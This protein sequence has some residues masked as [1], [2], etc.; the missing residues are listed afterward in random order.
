MSAECAVHAGALGVGTC[1]RCGAFACSA[2]FDVTTGWCSACRSRREVRLRVPG[3]ARAA[4]WLSVL[5]ACGVLPLLAVGGLLGWLELR[6]GGEQARP[7][8]QGA[9][10][11]AVGAAVVWGLTLLTERL[12]A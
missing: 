9:V 6:D 4:L 12:P 7:H 3:R 5:G 8:A 10:W 11:L 2:C 1:A